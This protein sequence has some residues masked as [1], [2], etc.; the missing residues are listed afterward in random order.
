MFCLCCCVESRVQ[1][2]FSFNLFL[3]FWVTN[4]LLRE[5]VFCFCFVVVFFFQEIATITFQ[6]CS[7]PSNEGGLL[8]ISF[9]ALYWYI[10]RSK[11]VCPGCR[12]YSASASLSLR[13]KRSRFFMQHS[14]LNR[15]WCSCVLWENSALLRCRTHSF[16]SRLHYFCR[17][18]A[19]P[20]YIWQLQQ[21][22]KDSLFFSFNKDRILAMVRIE[23][24]L[25]KT[26]LLEVIFW[27]TNQCQQ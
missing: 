13:Y 3:H 4:S 27:R 14:K 21:R 6:C 5:F 16:C 2:E 1:V 20:S 18:H 26:L 15:R 9:Q 17:E 10:F 24:C 8:W 7:R 25:R 12:L 11:R 19:T 22:Q 23:T